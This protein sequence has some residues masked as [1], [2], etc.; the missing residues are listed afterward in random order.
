M[1]D[2]SLGVFYPNG[3]VAPKRLLKYL[4]VTPKG[5]WAFHYADDALDKAR[6]LTCNGVKA[7]AVVNPTWC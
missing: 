4:V 1:T 2:G 7:T 3:S 5:A 6:Q